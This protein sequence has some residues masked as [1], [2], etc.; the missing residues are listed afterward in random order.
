MY[1]VIYVRLETTH[2]DDDIYTIKN[3]GLAIIQIDGGQYKL[4]SNSCFFI[5]IKQYL[6]ITSEIPFTLYDIRNM[7]N[8]N[9]PNGTE[10][11]TAYHIENI[12]SLINELNA[13][14]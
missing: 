6:D 5:A 9:Y 13:E 7:A 1:I 4:I 12:L 2:D 3:T 11:D 8:F 10:V 14:R